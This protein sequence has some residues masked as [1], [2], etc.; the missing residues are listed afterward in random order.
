MPA[1]LEPL[2]R[3]T[4]EDEERAFTLLGE[5]F[6][7]AWTL[8]IDISP[9]LSPCCSVVMLRFQKAPPAWHYQDIEYHSHR[10][11]T[12]APVIPRYPAPPHSF[13]HITSN[14]MH[15]FGHKD[16]DLQRRPDVVR[17]VQKAAAK[18]FS[19]EHLIAWWWYSRAVMPTGLRTACQDVCFRHNAASPRILT[20]RLQ[21]DRP[22][23]DNHTS[24]TVAQTTVGE[25]H[26]GDDI[27]TLRTN[28]C[29]CHKAFAGTPEP[30]G[31]V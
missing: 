5:I 2:S 12:V 23:R 14:M 25:E 24:A 31:C 22:D 30:G 8:Y 28:Q 13:R 15:S 6:P 3:M 10:E 19:S 18:R 17:H 26:H 11:Q 16:E 20:Q 4:D 9:A 1:H 27:I 7:C 21:W 29:Y